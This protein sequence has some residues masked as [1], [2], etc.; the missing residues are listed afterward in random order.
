MKPMTKRSSTYELKTS[1]ARKLHDL[2]F[3]GESNAGHVQIR[4]FMVELVFISVFCYM[5]DTEHMKKRQ[6]SADRP[7]KCRDISKDF[8][9]TTQVPSE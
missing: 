2:S 8:V 4:R 9:E 6:M 5:L 7:I 3:R 1:L